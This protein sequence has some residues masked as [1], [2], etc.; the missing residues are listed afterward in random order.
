MSRGGGVLIAI[1]AAG[2]GFQKPGQPV[3][4]AAGDG[5]DDGGP[6]SDAAQDP[7][8]L[9]ALTL[10]VATLSGCDTAGTADGPRE[11]ARFSNPVNVV[12]GPGGIAYVAD[13]DSNRVRKVDLAG[14]V[15]TVVAQ[16]NLRRPFG[17]AMSGDGY[18]YLETDDDDS[19]QHSLTTGTVW[20]VNPATGVAVVIARDLG[21]PRGLAVLPDGRIAMADHEH[22]VIQLLE[23]DTGVVTLLAGT[24]DV[25]G[26]A[27]G[28]G[29]LA[30]FAQPYD[31]VPYN[32]DLIVTDYDNQRLRRVTLTGVVTDFAGTGLPGSGNGPFATSTFFHPQGAAIDAS[33]A[34]YVTEVGNHDVRKIA[35]G[36]VSTV[37]GS[38]EAGW[39]D[40]N[41]PMQ[42]MFYGVEGLDVSAD[43]KRL[44]VADG[45]IGDG[46]P[47]NH[48][49]IVHQ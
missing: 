6:G 9:P 35:G 46:M 42:A 47:F 17:L 2:C 34:I 13:F 23:P 21:R 15:T 1:L 20:K 30:L 18:I 8:V 11:T 10:T 41:D 39:R 16:A 7:C 25:P 33:G 29:A 32:G 48:V 31:L 36:V 22:H 49:R 28:T 43:G 37:A 40:D 26:Y 44:V 14:K 4:A 38:T 24:L 45:N 12:L 27:N 5:G 19:G 3:D